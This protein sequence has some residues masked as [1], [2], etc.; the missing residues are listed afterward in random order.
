[1]VVISTLSATVTAAP[2]YRVRFA[3]RALRTV[4]R[5]ESLGR[6][7]TRGLSRTL[8]I[9]ALA[10]AFWTGLSQQAASEDFYKGKTIRVLVGYGAGGGYDIYGRI[11]AKYIREFIPGNPAVIVEN[12]PGAGSFGAAKYLYG[13]APKDGTSLGIVSQTLALDAAMNEDIDPA[14]VI[15]SSKI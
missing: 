1:M 7:F 12:M 11:F 6:Q 5:V 4:N 10:A 3:Q 14:S 15:P 13:A 8:M 9:C 2:V